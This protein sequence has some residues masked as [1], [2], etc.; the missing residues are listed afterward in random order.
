MINEK[1]LVDF[2]LQLI[3][4]STPAKNERPL[5]DI[6]R[7]ML[8]ELGF[9]VEE[10]DA[11]KKIGGN[12]GNLIAY[13]EGP[14]KT[15]HRIFFSAHMDTVS[16]T[17]D[18]KPHISKGIVRTS[19]DTIL[20]ADDKAGIAAIIEAMRVVEEQRIPYRSIQV[21]FDVA[22][23]IGLLGAKALDRKRIRADFGYVFDTEKPVAAL[24]VAAP[25][26]ENI[27]VKYTGRAAHA[28]IRPEAG[29]NAIVAASKAVANMRLGRIDSET[30]ANVGV[31]RGGTA[32]NIVPDAVEVLAEARSRDEDKLALQVEHMVRC[33]HDAAHEV[34]AN[35]D[36]EVVR[37]YD[38]YRFTADDLVVR[39][40]LAAG[41]RIGIEPELVEG[42][43][44]SDANIFNSHGL[45]AVVVG[46]GYENAHSSAEEIAISDL[47]TCARYVV[48]L[49]EAST[50]E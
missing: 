3:G 21:L 9:S 44:G 49:V 43:G 27:K 32:R 7:L 2:F 40:G 20:G 6:L 34:G 42:G 35:V 38:S 24:V 25:S 17:E 31:I 11:G 26:H 13:K 28:G 14:S 8:E 33:F 37:E 19:G 30:T 15:G 29:I 45:P 39:M 12:A 16:S 4:M 10:D 5:A 23:E 41:K 48:A 47:V 46:V 50:K 1:R 36:I 18:L 22:E